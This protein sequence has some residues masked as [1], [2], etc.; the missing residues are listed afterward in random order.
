MARITSINL[1]W[2]DN[3]VNFSDSDSMTDYHHGY[4]LGI[5]QTIE[6][7]KKHG[8]KKIRVTVTNDDPKIPSLRRVQQIA[9]MCGYTIEDK[10]H[11]H[12]YHGYMDK[13]VKRF[14]YEWL[15]TATPERIKILDAEDAEEERK[16]KE[17]EAYAKTPEARR[18]RILAEMHQ[19]KNVTAVFDHR[20]FHTV[21]EEERT[22]QLEELQKQLDEIS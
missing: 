3:Y 11:E 19:V 2:K 16:R 17:A 7:I 6:W 1:S 10:S 5:K 20:G 9:K 13:E 14:V 22:Q 15:L 8:A 4:S 21:T 12:T 18:K